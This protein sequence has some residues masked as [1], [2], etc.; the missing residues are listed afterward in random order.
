VSD[1]KT[2]LALPPHDVFIVRGESLRTRL[3]NSITV[4]K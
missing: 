2:T 4:R 1:T 3:G